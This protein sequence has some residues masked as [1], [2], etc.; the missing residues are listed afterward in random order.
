MP[1]LT[2]GPSP[3]GAPR[4]EPQLLLFVL[5]VLFSDCSSFLYINR[6]ILSV[7]LDLREL[8]GMSVEDVKILRFILCFWKCSQIVYENLQLIIDKIQVRL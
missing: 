2:S 8:E 1:K 4:S 3:T 6:L 5:G 7:F